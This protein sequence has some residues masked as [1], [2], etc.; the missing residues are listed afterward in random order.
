MLFKPE[1]MGVTATW[2]KGEGRR[3]RSYGHTGKDKAVKAVKAKTV[4][5]PEVTL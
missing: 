1:D 2:I 4:P 3:G 5:V